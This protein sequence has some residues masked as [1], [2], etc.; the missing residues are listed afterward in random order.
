MKAEFSKQSA[1]QNKL[2]AIILLNLLL[3]L[4]GLWVPYY[5]IDELTNALHARLLQSGDL[6]LRDF[7]GS[8]YLLTHYLYHWVYVFFE[9]N[10]LVPMHIFHVLWKSLTILALFWAGSKLDDRRTGLW[11]ALF[12]CVFSQTFMSKDFHTPSAESLSLLPAALC[13]GVFFHGI[14]KGSAW[15]FF[16]SGCLVAV[17][18]LFKA[19]IG[20]I[21]LAM[22]ISVLMMGEQIILRWILLML[23]FCVVLFFP[24]LFVSPLGQGFALMWTKVTETNAT[25]IESHSGL[26]QLYWVLKFFIRTGLVFACALGMTAFSFYGM[27]SVFRIHNKHRDIWQKIFFL[28]LWLILVWFTVAL[29][30]R[31]FYHY[32]VF[33]LVPLS[34]LAASGIKRFDTRLR[35]AIAHGDNI[36]SNR[37]LHHQAAVSLLFFIRK[38]LTFFIVLPLAVFFFEGAFNISTMPNDVD[39]AID[40]VNKNTTPKDRIYIWGNV[41]QLYFYSERLPSTAYF[42]SDILAGTSP[43]SPAMEYVRATGQDLKVTEMLQNDFDPTPFSKRNPQAFTMPK[44]FSRIG[45]SELF[46]VPELLARIDHPYWQKVFAD[47]LLRPP[48][49]FIDSSP[50][51]IRGFGYYPIHR[52][53]L[54]KRFVLDNYVLEKVVDG[55]IIY[56]I[57]KDRVGLMT[58]GI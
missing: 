36:K 14:K 5:N 31:V 37:N 1:T 13:A 48:T 17:A 23:G 10:S 2:A 27:R 39:K 22:A 46:T 51:N 3:G 7:L 26:S 35:A 29:G 19:P 54:L 32:Y 57:K 20:V 11:A 34:L 50:A 49:L 40:Y 41:P 56:R 55:L 53:E 45:E 38:R 25:Y 16:V 15:A 58:G 9:H 12:Y 4:P 28:S 43:G 18:T 24:A 44:N 33:L 6:D 21:G 42:W 30:K 52:Y 8:T 47:F